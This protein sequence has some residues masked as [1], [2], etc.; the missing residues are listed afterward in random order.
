ME[1][2][3]I[4]DVNKNEVNKTE[5]NRINGPVEWTLTNPLKKHAD[6]PGQLWI[7]YPLTKEQLLS[8]SNENQS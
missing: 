3:L 5:L 4:S 7:S 8:N 2:D 1:Q 6:N